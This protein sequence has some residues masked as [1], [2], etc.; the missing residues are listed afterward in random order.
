MGCSFFNL[1]Q[2]CL[3]GPGEYGSFTVSLLSPNFLDLDSQISQ[4]YLGLIITW[5]CTVYF[6]GSTGLKPIG[7]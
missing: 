6:N 4:L 3:L 1:T 2:F 5:F 7:E